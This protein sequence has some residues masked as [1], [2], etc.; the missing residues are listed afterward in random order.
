MDNA[1]LSGLLPRIER[2]FT[3]GFTAVQFVGQFLCCHQ[4]ERFVG[5]LDS[6]NRSSFYRDGW[7]P[8]DQHLLLGLCLEQIPRKALPR[9]RILL[10]ADGG[11]G[12]RLALLLS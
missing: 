5:V 8:H 3:S 6:G 1:R 10:L 7:M 4:G 9:V 2:R 11:C 12:P